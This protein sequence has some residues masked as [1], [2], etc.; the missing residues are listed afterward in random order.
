MCNYIIY[1]YELILD[2]ETLHS[3]QLCFLCFCSWRLHLTLFPLYCPVFSL[4]LFY[5]VL[6]CG[7]TKEDKIY[8]WYLTKG[9]DKLS[10]RLVNDY[11]SLA[12]L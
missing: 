1:V 7:Q 11:V 10:S 3:P 9:Y 5:L 2:S 6:H 8:K 12:M 4:C